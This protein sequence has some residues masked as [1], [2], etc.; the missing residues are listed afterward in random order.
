LSRATALAYM[1]KGGHI[2]TIHHFK[3]V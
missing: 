3:L 1:P 2:V